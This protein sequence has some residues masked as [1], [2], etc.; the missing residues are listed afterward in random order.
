MLFVK[1]KTEEWWDH[2]G[3]AGVLEPGSLVSRLRRFY[4]TGSWI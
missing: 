2:T 3:K 1:E 4:L